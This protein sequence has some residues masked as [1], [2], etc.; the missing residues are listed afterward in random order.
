[1]MSITSLGFVRSY[2]HEIEDGGQALFLASVLYN[3]FYLRL[4]VVLLQCQESKQMLL[5]F[6]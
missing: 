1:M 5:S 4:S 2:C 3:L 6:K